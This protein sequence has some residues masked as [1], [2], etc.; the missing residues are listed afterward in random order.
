MSNTSYL[1]PDTLYPY[2]QSISLRE[3][4]LLKE[5]RE[6]TANEPRGQ[7]QMPPEQGQFLQLLVKVIGAKRYLEIGV[8]TGYSTLAVALALP[9]DG[10]IVACD[11]SVE[12]T[13]IA[14]GFWQRAGVADKIDL[15]LAPGLETL[16]RLLAQG[17]RGTFD[18]VLIDADK[19][20]Y[21]SYYEHAYE[22]TRGGGLIA[23][24]NTLWYGKPIDA[25]DQS[26]DTVAIREFNQKLYRDERV[27]ISLLPIG[28]GLTLALKN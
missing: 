24:D 17:R 6:V 23:I 25:S 22:L 20:N 26:A 14:R 5:L 9:A 18:L 27:L 1:I 4:P 7:M 10:T 3:P 16:E 19:S 8:F 2:F 11:V 13:N 15:R 12:W 21:W 28:D